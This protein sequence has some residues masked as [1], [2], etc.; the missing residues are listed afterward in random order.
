[1]AQARAHS[2]ELR[3]R[4]RDKEKDILRV[5]MDTMLPTRLTAER[6]PVSVQNGPV[7][8]RLD[9]ADTLGQRWEEEDLEEEDLEK[10]EDLEVSK[11]TRRLPH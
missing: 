10:E 1:M 7:S 4:R 9:G 2:N 3:A 11:D 8:A 6:Y 5:S